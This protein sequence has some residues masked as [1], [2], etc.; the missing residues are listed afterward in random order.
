M[1]IGVAN[2]F[3]IY[4]LIQSNFCCISFK[5]GTFNVNYVIDKIRKL[6]SDL[7]FPPYKYRNAYLPTIQYR[8]RTRS[9]K[10][11]N[12]TLN[13]MKLVKLGFLLTFGLNIAAA[14]AS[15][16]TNN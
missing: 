14:T 10:I 9:G 11:D 13:T 4:P 6:M 15:K 3:L 16:L 5:Y 8:F 12:Q 2:F 1:F 7:F